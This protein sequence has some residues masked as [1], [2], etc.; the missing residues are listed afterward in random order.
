MRVGVRV[1]SELR[2]AWLVP[3]GEYYLQHGHHYS[4]Y[5]PDAVNVDAE[6]EVHPQQALTTEP[7]TF[8]DSDRS[9][10]IGFDQCL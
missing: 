3:S 1:W 9:L 6:A 2:N 4:R 10:V 8:S 7:R 5:G